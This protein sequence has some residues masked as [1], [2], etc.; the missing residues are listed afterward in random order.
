MRG[1]TGR[2]ALC[3]LVAV[4]VAR[5][6]EHEAG[7]PGTV[8]ASPTYPSL[9]I[10]GF[11]DVDFTATDEPG[12]ASNSRFFEGQLVLHLTSSLSESFTIISEVSFTAR[13]EAAV[14]AATP[15]FAVEVERVILR[16]TLSD[17]L[18]LSAGRFHTPISYWNVAYHHGQWLQTTAS[19]PDIVQFGGQF[20]PV[21]FVGAMA[22]GALPGSLGVGYAFGVGNG[23]STVISR[24]GDAGDVN[25]NRALVGTV[26]LRPGGRSDL[27]VG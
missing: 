5:A 14:N 16:Y 26:F 23:R 3:L 24:A 21:H 25:N 2:L 18:K 13:P 19:R 20:L 4:P 10:I 6:Q 1:L 27:Q 8:A 22:E 17:A 11:S 12:R 7:T 9:H 15:G